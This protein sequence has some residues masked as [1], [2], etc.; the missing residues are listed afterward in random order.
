MAMIDTH[1]DYLCDE[2]IFSAYARFL[3]RYAGDATAWQALPREV[4]AWWRRRD[5]SWLEYDGSAWQVMGPAEL[6]A[7]VTFARGSW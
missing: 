6:E 4:S 3:G 5:A 2:R 7:R 1:P